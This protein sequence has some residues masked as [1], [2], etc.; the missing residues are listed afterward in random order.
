MVVAIA[1][2]QDRSIA[3][4]TEWP[5]ERKGGVMNTAPDPTDERG[6]TRAR[7]VVVA[8][9]AVVALV[10]GLAAAAARPS[11]R[12]ADRTTPSAAATRSVTPEPSSSEPSPTVEPSDE[13]SAVPSPGAFDLADGIYPAFITGVDVSGGT[14]T[15]DL[16]QIFEGSAARRAALEDGVEPQDARYLS[17]Y[18]RNENDLLRT[19]E[20]SRDVRIRFMGTC[21]SPPNRHAALTELR[22]ETTP[23]SETFYYSVRL[24]AGQIDRLAQH[25]TISAC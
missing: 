16:I 1:P 15:V 24:M 21:E 25:L 23:Y 7:V 14:V 19:L 4:R 11:A 12:P 8:T 5:E 9:A 17:I 10:I 22:D 18:V 20:V 13:P 2:A 3:G 6:T